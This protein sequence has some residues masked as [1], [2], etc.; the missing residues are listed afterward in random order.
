MTG[1]E[2]GLAQRAAEQCGLL[3]LADLAEHGV[4]R[5]ARRHL[6]ESR[7]LELMARNV[8]GVVGSPASI[9]RDLR[10][11]LLCLGPGALVSHEAA[12]RLHRFDRARPDAVEFTVIRS[13]RSAACPFTVHSTEVLGRLDRVTVDGFACTSATRTIIDVARLRIPAIRLEAAIDS[14]VRTGASSPVTLAARLG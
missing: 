4:S 6:V 9:E 11:G 13:R 2:G 7:Q 1:M 3:S 10:L 8:Y 5:G 14:A 12:A